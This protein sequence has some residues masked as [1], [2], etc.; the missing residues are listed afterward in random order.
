M[1]PESQNDNNE[2]ELGITDKED[3]EALK[4]ALSA[5]KEKT[6]NYLA[7]WQRAQADFIN[8]KRHAE[9]EKQEISRFANSALILSLLPILDDLE[10]AFVSMP[11]EL[12][13]L[14]WIEGIRLIG[15]KLRSN[16]E[17]MGLSPIQALGEPFDPRLHEAVRQDNGKEGI[18]IGEVNKGYKFHDRV[19][20]PSQVV[21]G[22]GQQADEEKAG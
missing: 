6:E 21:V 3:I 5:E 10:R 8:Y 2:T 4:Q 18:I 19:I 15:R 12:A 20:R 9:Q 17:S 16:L 22:N 7:S 13:K 14:D 11:P 1:A